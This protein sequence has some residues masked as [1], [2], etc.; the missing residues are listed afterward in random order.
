[1]ILRIYDGVDA[2]AIGLPCERYD[3]PHVSSDFYQVFFIH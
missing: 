3:N 2:I 1:M